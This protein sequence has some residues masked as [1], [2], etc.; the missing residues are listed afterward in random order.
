MVGVVYGDARAAY[1]ADGVR[2]AEVDADGLETACVVLP[3]PAVAAVH[4][5]LEQVCS[6]TPAARGA[7]GSNNEIDTSDSAAVGDGGGCDG[8]SAAAFV[9]S[10]GDALAQTA[11]H[12]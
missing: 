3:I 8:P 7:I 1:V 2:R 5:L 9:E 4:G 10:V 6:S 12:V 11:A